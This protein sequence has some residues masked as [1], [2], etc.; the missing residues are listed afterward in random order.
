M[1]HSTAEIVREY[2]PFS[3]V[4]NV[5]G[6]TYDGQH[7]WFAA[8][9]KL[10]AFDPDSGKVLRSTDVAAHAGTAFAGPGLQRLEATTG[11]RDPGAGRSCLTRVSARTRWGLLAPL[12]AT[13]GD[14]G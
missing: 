11:G 3:G 2:G 12:L 5:G 6:V 4:A 10:N 9:D 14:S 1:R 13:R 8:G 7:V